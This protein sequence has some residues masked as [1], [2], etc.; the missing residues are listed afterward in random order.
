MRLPS[1]RWRPRWALGPTLAGLVVAVMYAGGSVLRDL[2]VGRAERDLKILI[3]R[4]PRVAHRKIG[5]SFEDV[6]INQIA[7]GD[8]IIAGRRGGPR[9]WTDHKS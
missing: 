1:Y 8:G 6:P 4:A 5:E 9:R 3:D 2:A 7:A